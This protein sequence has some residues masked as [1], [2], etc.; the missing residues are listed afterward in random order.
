[1]T[2]DTETDNAASVENGEWSF[3]E[4][5]LIDYEDIPEHAAVLQSGVVVGSEGVI[6]R[7]DYS[8]V[9]KSDTSATVTSED[10]E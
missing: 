8:T 1:M 7:L 9:P 10:G 6:G 3:D 4:L 2:E 5:E